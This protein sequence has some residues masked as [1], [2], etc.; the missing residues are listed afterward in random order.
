MAPPLR[1]ANP[2]EPF[3][4]DA[5]TWNAF[6]DTARTVRDNRRIFE[7]GPLLPVTSGGGTGG[8]SCSIVRF[9]VA[10]PIAGTMS[11]ICFIHAVDAGFTLA[12]VP[13]LANLEFS[14]NPFPGTPNIIVCD[15]MC[16]FFNEPQ[17]GLTNRLGWAKYMQPLIAN[18][19]QPN[20]AYLTPQW[21]VFA[22]NCVLNPQC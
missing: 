5:V 14:G 13:G 10:A 6:V 9:R 2:G 3:R 15:P 18:T 20:A 4:P 12:D 8:G 19:C 7:P 17:A 21:E 16:T 11:A 22:L 1:H